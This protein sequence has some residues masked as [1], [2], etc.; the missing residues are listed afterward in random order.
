M[1]KSRIVPEFEFDGPG[2]RQGFLRLFHSVHRSPTAS[3]RSRP[4]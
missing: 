3:S 4:G 2:K 1:T